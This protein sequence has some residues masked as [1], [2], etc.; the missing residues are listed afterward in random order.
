MEKYIDP[1]PDEKSQYTAGCPTA[2]PFRKVIDY[3]VYV[4]RTG[5][6]WKIYP[7]KK[8]TQT[9]CVIEDFNSN[10]LSWIC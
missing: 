6:Q 3:N 4:L 1:L 9:Q 5:Y 7:K 10:G 8:L 2:I